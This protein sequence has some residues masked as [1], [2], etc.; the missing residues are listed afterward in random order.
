MT[1]YWLTFAIAERMVDN[2]SSGD[3]KDALYNI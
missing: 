2:R 3:R 1:K